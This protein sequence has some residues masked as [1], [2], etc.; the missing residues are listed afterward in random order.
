MNRRELL[1]GAALLAGAGQA[2]AFGIGRLGTGLGRSGLLGRVRSAFPIAGAI[3][4]EIF[5]TGQYFPRAI[6]TELVDTRSTT[7][8][9]TD[10][11]GG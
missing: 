5:T 10:A 3:I 1:T 6:A 11:A 8:L 4:D 7:K 2:N 9:V